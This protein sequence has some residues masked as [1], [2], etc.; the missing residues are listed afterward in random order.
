MEGDA[1]KERFMLRMKNE[2]HPI[3]IFKDDNDYFIWGFHFYNQDERMT[4]FGADMDSLLGRTTFKI[5]S[6]LDDLPMVA[7]NGIS[8]IDN[9]I[10][11]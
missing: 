10:L 1:W 5:K 3:V 2:A 8:G 4:E 6:Y 7:E 11:N 9:D